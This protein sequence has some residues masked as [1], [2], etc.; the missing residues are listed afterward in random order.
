MSEDDWK[1]EHLIS[2]KPKSSFERR[3]ITFSA[4][5]SIAAERLRRA[6]AG[7]SQSN[8]LWAKQFRGFWKTGGAAR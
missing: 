4:T 1:G 5:S 6:G 3:S 2:A 7:V 8:T